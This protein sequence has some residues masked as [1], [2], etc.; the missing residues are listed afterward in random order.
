MR[1]YHAF[2]AAAVVVGTV[3]VVVVIT[4][5]SHHHLGKCTAHCSGIP[6][7]KEGIN[8]VARLSGRE[9]QHLV[10]TDQEQWIK[11]ER[12]R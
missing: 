7:V 2:A 6:N 9:G 1:R 5:L 8:A 3:V 4:Y 10:A 12:G 11:A